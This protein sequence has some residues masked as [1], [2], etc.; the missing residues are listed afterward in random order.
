MDDSLSALCMEG[1]FIDEFECGFHEKPVFRKIRITVTWVHTIR[2][3]SSNAF[4]M[5][6]REIGNA[7]F[8]SWA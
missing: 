7:V 3:I 2:S 6:F 5:R 8:N 1:K 4:S